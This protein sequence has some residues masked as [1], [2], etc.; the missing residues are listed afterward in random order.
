[1]SGA[2]SLAA[3]CTGHDDAMALVLAGYTPNIK[4]LGVSTVAS[5]QTVE[6][7]TRNA[8]DVLDLIGLSRVSK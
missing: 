7:T 8:L 5:N 4:L 1:M 6:K 3:P 2:R